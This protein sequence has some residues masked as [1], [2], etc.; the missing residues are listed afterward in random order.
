VLAQRLVRRLCTYCKTAYLPPPDL[1]RQV[2]VRRESIGDRQFFYG[3]GCP[4]CGQSGYRGRLGIF[5]WL[6]VSEPVRD[7]ITAKAPTLVIREKA[8]EHGMRPLREDGMRAL[9]DGF[10]AIEEIVKY[11]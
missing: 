7:L 3:R 4:T 2:G 10:T 9:F 5:E 11:T 6:R 8:I 1:L